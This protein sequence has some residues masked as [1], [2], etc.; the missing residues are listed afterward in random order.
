MKKIHLLI[1]APLLLLLVMA[2]ARPIQ[3]AAPEKYEITETPAPETTEPVTLAPA[4][5][6][7]KELLT[8][9]HTLLGT[10]YTYT[11]IT[12]ETGFDCSGFVTHV[13]ASESIKV[14]HSSALQAKEGVSV[15]KTAAQAGDIIIFTGTNLSVRTPGHTGIIL[16]TTNDTIS[17]IHS[18]SNGGVKISKVEGTRYNDRFLGI[19]RVL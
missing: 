17:F 14:P 3:F 13:F 12:P 10:P 5:D 1:L 15:T 19:R 4:A 18:S 9:A 11:G 6:T 8:Y 16:S 2:Y 7:A